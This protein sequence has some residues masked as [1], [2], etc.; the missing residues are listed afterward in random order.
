MSKSLGNAIGVEDPP[1]EIYGRT[2]SIPDA[3]MW[4][5]CL[6][7]TDVPEEELATRR[8]AV[9]AGGLHPME[10]K[11]ELAWG[12]TADYHG[13][14]AADVAQAEF[15]TVFSHSGVPEDIDEA[16]V[17]GPCRLSKALTA[18]GLAASNKE[19]QRLVRQ[20]AVT[21][22]GGRV[23]DPFFELT[24]RAEVYLLKVGKRRFLNLEVV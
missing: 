15:E 14:A 17:E 11:K 10:V 3:L 2:M 20:G 12:L 1:G 23:D 24:S 16:K 19:A 8:S 7:L 21:I 6:L 13:A 9:E 4:D 5:W 22:D 18:S